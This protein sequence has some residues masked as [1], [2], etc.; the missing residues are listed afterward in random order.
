MGDLDDYKEPT[1]AYLEMQDWGT[2]W[3][4]VFLDHNDTEALLAY[5]QQFYFGE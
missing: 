1:R 5:T 2:P 4:P 3:T